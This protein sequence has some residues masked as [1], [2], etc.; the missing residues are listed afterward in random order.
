MYLVPCIIMYFYLLFLM[1]YSAFKIQLEVNGCHQFT[2]YADL[3]ALRICRL[4][5][6]YAY[7][8]IYTEPKIFSEAYLEGR[9]RNGYTRKK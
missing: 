6:I 2:L 3:Y 9:Q 1:A 7:H 4:T 5:D 8:F